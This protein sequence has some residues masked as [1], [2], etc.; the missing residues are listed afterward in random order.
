MTHLLI[1][2]SRNYA[3]LQAAIEEMSAVYDPKTPLQ[4][5]NEAID[6]PYSFLCINLMQKD[7]SKMIM[8]QFSQYLNPS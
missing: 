5:Y 4:I 7:R 1:Y 6:E 2:I 8:Q 3:D